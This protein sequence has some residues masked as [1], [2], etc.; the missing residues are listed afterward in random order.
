MDTNLKRY[1]STIKGLEKKVQQLTQAVHASM[2]NDS[3]S[4]NQ[5][6]TMAMK[7]SLDTHCSTSLNSNTILVHNNIE[8][9]NVMKSGESNETPRSKHVIGTFAEKVKRR[10]AEE[11]EKTFLENLEKVLVNSPLIDTLRQT[12]DYTKIVMRNELPPKRKDPGSFILPCIVG[13]GN[14]KPVRML[15]EMAEKLMQSPKGI[16]ENILEG[17][18]LL[19]HMLGLTFLARKFRYSSGEKVMFN[20]NEGIPPL[21]VTSVYTINNFQVPNG[22][23]EHKNLE[24][25]LMNDEINGDL[26]DFLELD[27]LFPKNGIKP[28]GIPSDSKSEMGIGLEDFSRNQEDLL[29]EQAR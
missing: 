29:D 23:G 26:G 13:L 22:F 20:A 24:E 28:F 1:N 16:I 10:I 19:L 9:E 21:Y 8:Q 4:I 27:D 18:C 2:T 25:F 11:Q 7:N 5:V 12:P 17:P 3:K 6:K 14:P 15:I